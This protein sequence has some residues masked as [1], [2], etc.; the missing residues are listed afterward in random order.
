[1]ASAKAAKGAKKKRKRGKAAE[2]AKKKVMTFKSVVAMAGIDRAGCDHV[3]E[4]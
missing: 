2:N 1:M 3:F 4:L